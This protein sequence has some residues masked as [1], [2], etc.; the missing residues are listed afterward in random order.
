MAT[1]KVINVPHPTLRAQAAPV[2]SFD[3][4]LEALLDDMAE[5]MRAAHGV[6]LAG[7]Q[8]DVS[9]R[10]IVVEIGS[11]MDEELPPTLYKLVNPEITNFSL[12]TVIGAEGCLSIPGLMGDVERAQR[13]TLEAQD[14]RGEPIKLQAQGWLARVFQHEVDHLNG[15]LFTDKA[16]RV[17]KTDE[18]TEE[19]HAV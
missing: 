3:Q 13:I 4:E 6:G 14:P 11:E 9:R 1:R 12:E 2:T 18:E 5:T 8:I 7:P 17:W 10:V 19:Y 15:V 16:E